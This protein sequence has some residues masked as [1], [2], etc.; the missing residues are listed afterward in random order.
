MVTPPTAAALAAA[1]AALGRGEVVG[2]P[3]DTVYGLAALA[4]SPEGCR[5]IFELKGR[6]AEVG[7]PVLVGDLPA[8]LALAAPSARAGLE[9]LAAAF[10]PGPLTVVVE[11]APFRLAHLGGVGASI[12]LRLPDEP[13]VS[14]LCSLAGPLAVTS[15]NPHGAPPCTRAAEVEASFPGGLAAVLDGGPRDG[16]PSSVVSLLGGHPV[17]LREGPVAREAVEVA[18]APLRTAEARK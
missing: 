8:A 5:R 2:V 1:A 13:V 12:G 9:L 14:A 6:P 17:V 10:W 15:A 11:A 16:V 3:T 18:L 4:R 7:L